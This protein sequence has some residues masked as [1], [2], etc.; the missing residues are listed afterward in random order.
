MKK[1][2]LILLLILGVVLGIYIYSSA[3]QKI[4]LPRPEDKAGRE[5]SRFMPE[6]VESKRAP[7][8]SEDLKVTGP[9]SVGEQKP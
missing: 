5:A 1:T 4:S 6:E 7:K 3:R 8:G 9:V 2:I